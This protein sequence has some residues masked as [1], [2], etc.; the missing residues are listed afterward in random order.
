MEPDP[1]CTWISA[2]LTATETEVYYP[3]STGFLAQHPKTEPLIG[4]TIWI[5]PKELASGLSL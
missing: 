4:G 3:F 2:Q 1:K 5:A